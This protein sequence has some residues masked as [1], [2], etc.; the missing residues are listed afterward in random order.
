MEKRFWHEHRD[1]LA[2]QGVTR[3]S[4]QL[5]RRIVRDFYRSVFI[6]DD[7][8]VRRRNENR[9]HQPLALQRRGDCVAAVRDRRLALVIGVMHE[10]RLARPARYRKH[11]GLVQLMG[12][13]PLWIY[14]ARHDGGGT[15]LGADLC[16]P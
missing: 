7:Y 5:G 1:V 14:C 4:E 11:R 6:D 8:R 9:F 15:S 10:N 16:A 12:P 13:S 2:D 3:I